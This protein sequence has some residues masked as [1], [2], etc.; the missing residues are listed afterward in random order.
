MRAQSKLKPFGDIWH[1]EA[2]HQPKRDPKGERGCLSDLRPSITPWLATFPDPCQEPELRGKQNAECIY[3]LNFWGP[4]NKPVS[5]VKT[6]LSRRGEN[7]RSNPPIQWVT[8]NKEGSEVTINKCFHSHTWKRK[9]RAGSDSSRLVQ[10]PG[11]GGHF[12]HVNEPIDQKPDASIWTTMYTQWAPRGESYTMIVLRV[13]GHRCHVCQVLPHQSQSLCCPSCPHLAI[14]KSGE[15]LA[16]WQWNTGVWVYGCQ[17]VCIEFTVSNSD[18][19]WHPTALDTQPTTVRKR[20]GTALLHS[21][22]CLS[23]HGF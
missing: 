15:T 11:G 4:A 8:P 23:S 20:Y 10:T 3:S 22:S 18:K 9:G 2:P 14:K 17:A 5:P 21:V 1:S 19:I 12:F 16:S 7:S 6:H 13:R